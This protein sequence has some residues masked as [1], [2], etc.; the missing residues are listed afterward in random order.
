MKLHAY[1][2]SGIVVLAAGLAAQS[3]QQAYQQSSPQG[4]PQPAPDLITSRGIQTVQAGDPATNLPW[5]PL[6]SGDLISITVRDCPELTRAFRVGE[7]GTLSLPLLQGELQVGGMKPPDVEALIAAKVKAA[8]LLVN[9]SVTVAVM[10]YRSR[11]IYVLGAVRM[12]TIIQVIGEV[13]LLDVLTRAQGLAPEAGP[14]ILV[15][16]P[17]VGADGKRT[18][19]TRKV[20]T[21]DLMHG[22][23][24]TSNMLLTGGEEIRV[25][26]ADKIYVVGDVKMPS[27]VPIHEDTESTVLKVLAQCQGLAPYPQ[28]EAFVYRTKPGTKEREEITIPLRLIVQ[29]KSPDVTLLPNDVLYVPEAV[30]KRLTMAALEKISELGGATASGM[31]IWSKY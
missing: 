25:P 18:M 20:A 23:D 9:P 17:Q 1:L 31:A 10:E 30:G 5:M 27:A 3:G 19:I 16:T 2:L 11:P 15:S 22:A 29:R 7:N 4:P 24:P 13:R 6:G 8:H 26:E 12:P 28:K 14:E 21:R